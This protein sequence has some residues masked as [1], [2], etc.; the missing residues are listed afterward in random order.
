MGSRTT[1]VWGTLIL[2]CV[3]A[4]SL[5]LWVLQRG[6]KSV[7][8]T[9]HLAVYCDGKQQRCCIAASS[10]FFDNLYLTAE[11][12]EPVFIACVI[13]SF[14]LSIEKQL[15]SPSAGLML[16][17]RHRRWPNIKPTLCEHAVVEGRC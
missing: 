5:S 3:I 9:T 15:R 14:L 6:L 2:Y 17:Q 11:V 12:D 10:H 1:C 13:F 4:L 8:A 16:G 7:Q